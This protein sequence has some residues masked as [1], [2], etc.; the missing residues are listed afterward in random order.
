MGK[1]KTVYFQ[2]FAHIQPIGATF[3]VTFRLVDS[4][5]ISHLADLKSKYRSEY[6]LCM[7]IEDSYLKNSKIFELR[8]KYLIEYDK[9]LD[10]T[11]NGAH[12]LKDFSVMN[13]VKTQL[14]T[15]D[16]QLYDLIAYCIMSN[17]VHILIDTSIQMKKDIY[18]ENELINNYLPL[19]KIMKRIKGATALYA[20]QLLSR[21]GKFWDKESYDIFIRNEYMLNNVIAYILNNPLKAGL[22]TH[23]EHYPGNFY[24][25]ADS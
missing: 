10:L 4:I 25:Y 3:F 2:K 15:H 12:H 13:M 7:Q 19:D 6:I 20:N 14:H 24:K 11:I 18:Y 23:W 9:I 8:K 17:H 22:A 5:P 1:I 21:S 16:G